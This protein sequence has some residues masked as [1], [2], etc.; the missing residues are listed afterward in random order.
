MSRKYKQQGYQDSDRRD[1]RGGS[2]RR[3]PR[4]ELSAEERLHRKGM[5]HAID[6]EA[7]EVVRCHTC[8]RSNP[9]TE[10]IEP[11]TTCLFCEAAIHCC[12]LCTHF[13]SSAPKQCREEIEEAIGDKTKANQC[14]KYVARMV[15]DSTGRRSEKSSPGGSGGS[16][17]SGGPRDAFD[18]LFKR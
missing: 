12:R 18:S 10:V 4:V 2:D 15:L 14:E 17:G 1:D 16:R 3:P 6:R 9:H 13:D 8:G 11:D 7:R 5:R